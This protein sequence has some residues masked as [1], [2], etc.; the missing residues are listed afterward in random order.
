MFAPYIH[1][2]SGQAIQPQLTVGQPDDKYEREADAVADQVMRMTDPAHTVQRRCTECE[3]EQMQRK[4]LANSRNLIQRQP[5]EQD[6]LIQRQEAEQPDA[7]VTATVSPDATENT[8]AGSEPSS[9]R[10]GICMRNPAFPDFPCL[11]R[12]LKL[13]VDDNIRTN[14]HHFFRIATLF[15]DRPDLMW[16]TFMRYGIGV[17]LLQTTYGFLGAEGMLNNVLSYGTGI[18]FKAYDFAKNGVLTLDLPIPLTDSLNLELNFDLAADPTD[19]YRVRGLQTG[20][21][22]S[23]S[24]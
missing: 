8:P 4:P 13:D 10:A 15:P 19:R 12:A 24:F 5:E 17:N 7:T 21:G 1:K 9:F 18:G 16:N 20:V 3:H 6:E 11:L 23:G 14:A 22:L 2:L